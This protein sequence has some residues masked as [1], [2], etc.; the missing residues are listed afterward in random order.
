[1]TPRA[2]PGRLVATAV[3]A[4]IRDTIAP[5]ASTRGVRLV[6][7]RR[8]RV[9]RSCQESN[10]PFA[11]N[12]S[13]ATRARSS[14][15]EPWEVRRKPASPEAHR[16]I[17]SQLLRPAAPRPRTCTSTNVPSGV[18]ASHEGTS[19]VNAKPGVVHG[20][21]QRPRSQVRPA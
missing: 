6:P 21:F 9:M 8:F 17:V 2:T 16:P 10:E 14:V 20:D 12:V 11:T 18:R 1:M 15:W 19:S 3:E 13:V 7:A 4:G 5:T